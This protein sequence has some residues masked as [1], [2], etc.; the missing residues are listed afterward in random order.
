M[1]AERQ[2]MADDGATPLAHDDASVRGDTAAAATPPPSTP[3]TPT[4]GPV[5]G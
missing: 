2:T 3:A 1:T 5:A 4:V